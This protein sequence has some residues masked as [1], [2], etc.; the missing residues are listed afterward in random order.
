MDELNKDS[1]RSY[2]TDSTYK[3]EILNEIIASLTDWL[4]D[5]WSVVFEHKSGFQLGHECL[6]FVCS[7]LARLAN[8]RTWSVCCLSV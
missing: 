3:P 8:V 4:S 7:T 6:L 2:V 5:I 1:K